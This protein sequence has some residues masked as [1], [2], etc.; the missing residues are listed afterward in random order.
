MIIITVISSTC[1]LVLGLVV[2]IATETV[3]LNGC[4]ALLP[5]I[6]LAQNCVI[7]ANE[8]LL[9]HMLDYY[10]NFNILTM[11][12]HFEIKSCMIYCQPLE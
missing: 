3:C 12:M 9:V 11:N 8:P 5:F 2:N 10:E 6:R 1:K 4:S 7:D